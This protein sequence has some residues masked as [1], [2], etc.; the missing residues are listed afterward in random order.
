M[1]CSRRLRRI[2]KA[3]HFTQGHRNK[4]QKKTIT[5]DKIIDARSVSGE[6]STLLY[7]KFMF[8][9]MS[10]CLSCC[11]IC[12]FFC[13]FVYLCFYLLLVCLFLSVCLCVCLFRYLCIQLFCAERA[14]AMSMELKQAAN[15]EP[16]K[17]FH[18][19]RRLK[20]A[21]K[22]AAELSRLCEECGRCDSRTRLEAQ[23][24]L[25]CASVCLSVLHVWLG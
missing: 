16:R 25:S 20:R 18:L 21:G 22:H 15:T 5:V 11:F 1:Y 7:R 17:R 6:Q 12:L 4:Y 3:L 23:V 24:C 2:R 13:P 19:L 9:C 10:V 14:W 8:F